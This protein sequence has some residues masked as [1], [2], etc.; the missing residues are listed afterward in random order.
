MNQMKNYSIL[1]LL[2]LQ[3]IS[4]NCFWGFGA[5]PSKYNRV[6]NPFGVTGEIPNGLY[7]SHYIDT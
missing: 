4:V 5:C 7:Y 2:A 1:T 3:L 6:K